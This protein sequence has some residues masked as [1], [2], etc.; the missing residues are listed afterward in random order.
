LQKIHDEEDKEE[1]DGF[2]KKKKIKLRMEECKGRSLEE[3]ESL[4]ATGTYILPTK[5]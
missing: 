4:E 3:L 5:Y 1:E 2:I